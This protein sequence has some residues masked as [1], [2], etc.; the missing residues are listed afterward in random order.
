MRVVSM[1]WI[2]VRFW[3]TFIELVYMGLLRGEVVNT[4]SLSGLF[5]GGGSQQ[6]E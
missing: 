3:G 2:C 4:H 6:R 5:K 1:A